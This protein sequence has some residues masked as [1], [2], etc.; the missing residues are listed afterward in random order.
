MKKI[1]LGQNISILANLGVIAGIV[2]LA[3]EIGQ[4]QRSLD[5]Q[6]M[7]TVLSGQESAFALMG[8]FRRLRME[9]PELDR[10]WRSGLANEIQNDADQSQFE[11]LCE[12]RIFVASTLYNRFVALNDSMAAEN[13]VYGIRRL[14]SQS[15]T[16]HECWRRIREVALNSGQV[17]F[18]SA[19]DASTP[20]D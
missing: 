13:Q 10:I 7:L 4:N 6:N 18:V 5:E 2:F 1:D 20:T 16:F 11:L 9:N 8:S 3:V 15:A 14:I 12:D 17:Q 19:V